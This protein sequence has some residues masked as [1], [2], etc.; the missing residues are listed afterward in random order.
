MA[1]R[2]VKSPAGER[3]EIVDDQDWLTL[4]GYPSDSTA[5]RQWGGGMKPYIFRAL[6]EHGEFTDPKSGRVGTVL[7][8][9][10]AEHYP[11]AE[12]SD[13]PATIMALFRNSVNSPAVSSVMNGKRTFS[14]KLIALPEIW[15]RKLLDDIARDKPQEPPQPVQAPEA[16]E[17]AP[18]APQAPT[19]GNGDGVWSDADWE[20][21]QLDAPT[22]Y[23]QPPP[24]ELHIA[25][26]VAMSLLTTVVEIISSGSADTS[27]LSAGQ[28]VQQELDHSQHL[29]A[30]RLEENE[31]LR[32]QLREA[33]DAIN[34][35]RQE[36][37]GL[38]SRLR[39]TEYNL[40]Q[41]LKGET[42][43][44][45]NSEI[46]KRMDQFMRTAPVNKGE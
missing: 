22:V 7:R 9:H 2:T 38:R 10:M 3:I 29:L 8:D 20:A 26:Q 11:N 15:H 34:A 13:N 31:K 25:N 16:Q 24:M 28:R 18:E 17:P 4:I 46:A 6:W 19:Q 40:S 23:E 35:L 5:L 27:R 45:V 43:Q 42:A 41:V 39:S 14:L 33:G 21:L 37:D 36:R 12:L 44:A 32:R 30:M 1:S